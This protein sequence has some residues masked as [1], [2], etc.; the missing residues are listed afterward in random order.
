MERKG[1]QDMIKAIEYNKVSA[2]FVKD[3]SR[4]RRNYIEV[5]K[6]T[7]EFLPDHDNRLVAV[8][9]KID[10][11]E[12][13]N[14]LAPIKN[15]FNEWY[16]RDIS[17][18]RRISNKI[19][20][21]AGETLGFPLYGYMKNSNSS[22][23]WVTDKEA[24]DIVK[25][26]FDMM[27]DGLGSEQIAVTLEQDKINTPSNYWHVKGVKQLSKPNMD[28]P[29]SWNSSTVIKILTIQECYGDVINFNI[30]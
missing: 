8:S 17:K 4:L 19:K 10:T 5:G 6:L 14:E 7:E 30:Y 27:L 26:I 20:G 9:D 15:L 13:E 22:K 23:S 16:A 11:Y 1:Y 24:A 28:K 29:Y 12:G 25:R 2:V 21:D 18:K 3:L